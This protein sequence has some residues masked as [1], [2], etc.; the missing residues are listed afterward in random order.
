MP[1][2]GDI[3]KGQ[4]E[5]GDAFGRWNFFRVLTRIGLGAQTRAQGSRIDQIDPHA[6]APCLGGVGQ[7]HRLQRRL[8]RR[9]S[10]PERPRRSRPGAGHEN[11]PP[12]IRGPKQRVK[13]A[14]EAE[15]GASIERHDP[16]EHLWLDMPEWRKLA[17]LR[18]IR[19][20]HVQPAETLGKSAPQLIDRGTV[21]EIEWHQGRPAAGRAH[22]VV[23]LFQSARGPRDQDQV[24][25]FGG[26]GFR[27]RRPEA[28]TG[29]GDQNQPVGEAGQLRPPPA[30]G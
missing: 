11:R 19:D 20:Q 25:A 29:A 10:A 3:G 24:R 7:D 1:G 21:Q 28:T 6:K 2:A 27:K 16:L 12:A 14:D 9:I 18:G 4:E 15:S 13:G 22:P 17:Q 23:D 5:P 26:E 30:A 8:A